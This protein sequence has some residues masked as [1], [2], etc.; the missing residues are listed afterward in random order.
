MSIFDHIGPYRLL[1]LKV[2]RLYYMYIY[3]YV[4]TGVSR[5][6]HAMFKQN[7]WS[8]HLHNTVFPYEIWL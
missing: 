3:S 8:C 1:I 2:N 7:L 4:Y 6:R 5:A